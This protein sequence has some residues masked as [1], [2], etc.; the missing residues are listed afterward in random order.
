MGA[1]GASIAKELVN[2]LKRYERTNGAV[3]LSA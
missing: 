3:W 1:D 2:V